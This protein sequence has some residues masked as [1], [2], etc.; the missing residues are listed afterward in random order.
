MQYT[1]EMVVYLAFCLLKTLF[2]LSRHPLFSLLAL[3]LEKCEQATLGYVSN[4]SSSTSSRSSPNGSGNENNCENDS[5]SRDVQVSFSFNHLKK[6]Q[7]VTYFIKIGLCAVT[8][9]GKAT[10][11][12]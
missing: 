6:S 1:S 3:L 9:E 10:T 12:D 5:F 4:S 7:V 11:V 2:C 8:G